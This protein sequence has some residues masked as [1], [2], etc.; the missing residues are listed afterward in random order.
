MDEIQFSATVN[1]KV[2][3]T[4]FYKPTFSEKPV[5]LCQ[6]AIS[7]GG[8][9]CACEYVTDEKVWNDDFLWNLTTHKCHGL[10]TCTHAE[11][12][13][14]RA[15]RQSQKRDINKDIFWSQTDG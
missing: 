9:G 5:D 6:Q 14:A 12:S 7:G 8:C 3:V 1:S 2:I 15:G 11:V 4:V 10:P 13:P